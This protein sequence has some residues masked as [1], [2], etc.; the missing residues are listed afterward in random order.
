MKGGAN[1]PE[2]T[3]S[4]RSACEEF[5]SHGGDGDKLCDLGASLG[6]ALIRGGFSLAKARAVILAIDRDT[7]LRE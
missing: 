4:Y 1:I 3:R 5:A 7:G 2:L 6:L